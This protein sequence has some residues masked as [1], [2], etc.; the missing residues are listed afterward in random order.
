MISQTDPE[1]YGWA[2]AFPVETD[3][4]QWKREYAEAQKRWLESWNPPEEWRQ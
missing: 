3:D 1:F 4:P 2:F